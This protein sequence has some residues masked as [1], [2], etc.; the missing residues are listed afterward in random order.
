M[1]GHDPS[2]GQHRNPEALVGAFATLEAMATTKLERRARVLN[3]LPRPSTRPW[4]ARALTSWYLWGVLILTALSIIGLIDM[5][6]MMGRDVHLPDGRIAYG[7]PMEIF[8]QA[9]KWAWPTAAVWSLLFLWLDRY[10]RLNVPLYVM[11]F[12]WGGVISTWFSI[13]VN[14]WMGERLGVTG[15]DPSTGA[16]SAVFSAPFVEE[17]SKTAIL[18]LLAILLRYRIVSTLQAVTLAGFSAIG[19]AF[20]EN[21]VYYARA[22]NYATQVPGIDPQAEVMSLVRLRGIWT[23]F[24]HPLFTSLAAFGIAV[25][26]RHRSKLVRVFAPLAGF[27]FAALGHMAFNGIASTTPEDKIKNYWYMALFLVASIVFT[28]VGHFLMEM[29]RIRA[30]LVDFVRMGWLEPQDAKSFSNPFSRIGI[31]FIAA[32]QP[33]RF[34]QTWMNMRRLT[35]L[36]YLR[37]SMTRGLVDEA[38]Y[39]RARELVDLINR[40]RRVAVMSTSEGIVWPRIPAFLRRLVPKRRQPAMAPVPVAP[41]HQRWGPPRG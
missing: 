12:L 15:D 30:R 31:L 32:L 11:A 26:L 29:R 1:R 38:G 20:I 5:H 35:E 4:W 2:A 7:I 27:A 33:S 14:T 34:W 16:R 40:D 37:D 18:F 19:F 13:Y 21:I 6:A 17:I 36:A 10:R 39:V 22:Y 8:V 25:G 9:A 24:G 28:L 23:S 3:G 41:P